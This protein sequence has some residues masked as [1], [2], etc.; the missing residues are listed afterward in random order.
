M[1][2]VFGRIFEPKEWNTE[3]ID[4]VLERGDK[5]CSV[6]VSRN[7][8][9][10]DT[11]IRTNM[12]YHAFY[13]DDYKMEICTSA[14]NVTGNLFSSSI[15]CPSLKE[16]IETYFKNNDSGVISTQESSVAVWR[17]PS[18]EY[19]YFDPLPCS[20][21]GSRDRANGTSCLLKFKQLDD[22]LDHFLSNL[23]N[24]DS[25][26]Y[27]DKVSLQRIEP[28][29]ENLQKLDLP[30]VT[31]ERKFIIKK[32]II[33]TI[34]KVSFSDQ[35]P[36]C[37]PQSFDAKRQPKENE[38]CD[39]LKVPLSITISN[40]DIDTTFATEPMID[41]NSFDTGYSYHDMEADVP[42][43]LVEIND[44]ISIL[45]GR[46]H[47]ASTMYRNK[48]AQNVA[49]GIALQV[50]R[51]IDPVRTWDRDRLDQILT[52]GDT[53][54]SELKK[55]KPTLKTITSI[56]FDEFKLTVEERKFLVEVH[57]ITIIG[58]LS[59]EEPSVLNLKQGLDEFFINNT[60]GIIECSAMAIAVWRENEFFYTFDP[61]QCDEKGVHMVADKKSSRKRKKN[62]GGAGEPIK[63]PGKCCVLQFAKLD[64]LICTFMGNIVFAKKNDKFTIR[65]V[66]IL[67]D[68]P[69]VRPW[70]YFQPG[71]YGR[72]WILRG[73]IANDEEDLE[74]ESSGNQGLA[75]PVVALIR[76]TEVPPENWSKATVDE[77]IRDGDAYYNWC[78]PADAEEDMKLSPINLKR[79]LYVTRRKVEIAF[80]ESIVSGDLRET[81]CSD[82]ISLGDAL[83]KFFE[84]NQFGIVDMSDY[85]PAVWKYEEV[86]K[87]KTKE[88][89]YYMLDSN[90]RGRYGQEIDPEDEEPPVGCVV[91]VKDLAEIA[92]VIINNIDMS[93]ED[94]KTAF[95][96]HSIKV[97][98]IGEPM[99][100]EELANDKQIPIRPHLNNYKE[101]ASDAACLNGSFNQANEVLFKEM[102]RDKQQAANALVTLA[103]T[104]LFPPQRWY[105]E[106]VDEI[107]K[108][109]NKLS[110]DLI[111]NII[112]D[113]EE[114]A[115]ADRNYLLPDEIGE[116]IALGVNTMAL[117]L[118]SDAATGK[119][120]E[121]EKFLTDFFENNAMGIFRVNETMIPIWK[122]N[123]LYFMMD[124]RGRDE[125]GNVKEK[126]GTAAVMWF[127]NIPSFMNHL[128]MSIVAQDS[129]FT[130]DSVDIENEYEMQEPE[131]EPD[132]EVQWK[133]FMKIKDGVWS[134]DG[135][136]L[137]GDERFSDE[138]KNQQ[139]AAIAATA[140]VFS[141]VYLPHQWKSEVLDEVI[142][143][144]DK[145][146]S[147][148]A[149][150]LNG[151]IPEINEIVTE[152]FLSNR[153]I[154]LIVKYSV[155][156][157]A[158]DT[159]GTK[160]QDLLAGMTKF[161]DRHS[162]GVLTAED[163]NVAIW[164]FKG[165]YYCVVPGKSEMK[166][167]EEVQA[168]VAEETAEQ[169][170]KQT[171][172][173]QIPEKQAPEKKTAD[174]QAP[175]NQ[176]E[177][178]E[179]E[180]VVKSQ[181]MRFSSVEYLTEYLLEVLKEKKDYDITAVNVTDLNKKPPWVHDPSPAVQPSNLPPLNAYHKLDKPARAILR[182]T[183]HQAST[184]FPLATR[185]QQSAANCVV[186]LGMAVIKNPLTWTK[187]ILEEM[188]I[189][190][191][192]VHEKSLIVV[193][194]D[195][196]QE[197]TL[198]EII[199][200]F[201]IGNNVF[202]ADIESS[203]VTGKVSI[204][205]PEPEVT[206]KKG[207]RG[208]RKEKK[209]RKAR[210]RK[211]LED[212]PPPPPPPILLQEGLEKF[213]AS[214]RAGVLVI[215]QNMFAV[216]KDQGIYF[217]FDPKGCDERGFRD[218][219]G[220]CCTMW[221]A[222]MQPF[223][224][225]IFQKVKEH[226]A[227]SD[228]NICHV[229]MKV[230]DIKTLPCPW[231]K[232]IKSCLSGPKKKDPCDQFVD[233]AY[234]HI[235]R[236]LSLLHGSLHLN[237]PSFAVANQ[238]S[239][240]TAMAAVAI[241]VSDVYDPLIWNTA[242]IDDI[243]YYGDKLHLDSSRKFKVTAR[244]LSP[245]EV[246]KIFVI[247]DI[248]AHINIHKYTAAGLLLF[249]DLMQSLTLFFSKHNTG[250]LHSNNISF[251]LIKYSKSFYLFDP[252]PC[253]ELGN[254]FFTGNACVVKISD[255]N[256][257]T[258][259]IIAKCNYREPNVYTINA[260]TVCH[261]HF[262]KT[263]RPLCP[264]ACV[265]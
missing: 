184:I 105:P 227:A 72:S 244:N 144:G 119:V 259:T 182:G 147:K 199:R 238:G 241:V 239:Q 250:I 49:N 11:Y 108:I 179:A 9:A 102:T 122:E 101:I 235:T 231:I 48:G 140:V 209:P 7:R 29:A 237:S 100:E 185:N 191:N 12:L 34:N 45:R 217:M 183:K 26:Y 50:T 208:R 251:A 204:P 193:E 252:F 192:K 145:L 37:S 87:N 84:T 174:K 160:H 17:H 264:P 117:Y 111:D 195:S 188:L 116:E 94:V 54:H 97:N 43:N 118:E 103:M 66:E 65:R 207:K 91:R 27:I 175:E 242:I 121:L 70:Y 253:N 68:V 168:E 181:A 35:K 16:S 146:H 123:D 25:K 159:Y 176:T 157:G 246:L 41:Q 203:T 194:G 211:K 62:K 197:L 201:F 196:L 114:D 214:N 15:N 44:E 212:L 76:A 226:D 261:L 236:D 210:G 4:K 51:K 18:C 156:S 126:D 19:L 38:E 170:E 135:D 224:D 36:L 232:S 109:G 81:A 200:V 1:A 32:D 80:N 75:M 187:H 93:E 202:T 219:K 256:T 218:G 254:R 99:T 129:T 172:E 20:S 95:A 6:S 225:M 134:I 30:C 77:V 216:W 205:P 57:F 133:H 24:I 262:F 10:P 233:S 53:I 96:I 247:A 131:P 63:L 130:I 98:S 180:P 106:T 234:T 46:T 223:Y 86:L 2:I 3:L 189:I 21:D 169:P 164:Q 150:R 52:L 137:M 83:A 190:G 158:I 141:K 220:A 257:L 107:L 67:D 39:V 40:Y 243:L 230:V 47:E 23:C 88:M 85:C 127:M 138:N 124:P 64:L 74:D 79:T 255:L 249:S 167:P 132:P 142:I 263:L 89:Y 171:S 186:A 136:L 58:T 33:E 178:A 173:K 92:R 82:A 153:R 90:P 115:V 245:L 161:L 5:L 61:H 110:F 22:L 152:F 222:C 215:G 31:V 14:R 213:F 73:T 69:G 229:V 177:D 165:F 78:I 8:V 154:E 71:E 128:Q 221:F 148:C 151:K 155:E 104:K 143:T 112:P 125:R 59:S 258:K 55:I 28:I 120:N 206:G 60:E 13:I 162:S 163:T 42:T 260:V 240:S 248:R 198:S 113:E 56:D 139:S 265:P 228:F 149:E 166:Q